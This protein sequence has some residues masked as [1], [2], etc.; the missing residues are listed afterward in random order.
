MRLF[1][2]RHGETRANV[3]RF[4]YGPNDDFPLTPLGEEQ[5]R[6]IRPLLENISFDKVYSSDFLRAIQTQRLAI[7]GVEGIRE[8]LLREIEQGALGGKP[9]AD[10]Y[11]VE[12]FGKPLTD[13]RGYSVVGGESMEDVANRLRIFL[14]RL[15]EDPCDNVAAVV[16]NGVLSCMLRL[17]LG[18]D[19]FA[20]KAVTSGNCAIHVYEFDGTMWK[21]LSW[22]YGLKLD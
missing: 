7:P 14:K 21:L 11:D 1:M 6:S 17:V 15:E 10:A 2:I 5:A 20:R 3:G 12:R 18:A 8:P 4:F 13:E 9:Y 19:T 16:H 22:N